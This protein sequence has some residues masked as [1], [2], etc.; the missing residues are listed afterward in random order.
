[1]RAAELNFPGVI[2]FSRIYFLYNEFILPYARKDCEIDE[3]I[4]PRKLYSIEVNAI[5]NL[6]PPS[7]NWSG[8]Y[9]HVPP[10]LRWA[11]TGTPIQN[12]LKDFYSLVK[13]MHLAPFDDYRIW[14][15]TVE[16]KGT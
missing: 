1:M 3:Y 8:Y 11:V 6:I 16:Q 13:F 12:N 5:S 4:T 10:D 14:K 15:A 9:F 2:I 7:L